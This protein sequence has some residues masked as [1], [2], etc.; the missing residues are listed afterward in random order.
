MNI[1]ATLNFIIP[2]RSALFDLI[3]G[4]STHL[5]MELSSLF[6]WDSV[7][8]FR[9][10]CDLG[11]RFSVSWF[12]CLQWVNKTAKEPN[13]NASLQTQA[14][15][16]TDCLDQGGMME[17]LKRA[18]K[19][20]PKSSTNKSSVCLLPGLSH[21]HT[22]FPN[23]S[24]QLYGHLVRKHISSLNEYRSSCFGAPIISVLASM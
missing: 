6:I 22:T 20:L 12:I 8:F 1:I 24:L 23:S 5:K 17:E 15:S 16:R 11:S 13:M 21:L 9:S 3:Q 18:K 14:I 10:H 19:H 7:A 4:H 2:A